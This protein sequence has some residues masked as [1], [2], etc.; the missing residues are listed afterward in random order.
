MGVK[1]IMLINRESL[2]IRNVLIII[3]YFF[4]GG[5]KGMAL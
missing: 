1:F 2:N 3:F 5:K 4:V